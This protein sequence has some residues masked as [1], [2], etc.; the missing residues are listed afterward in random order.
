MNY[1]EWLERTKVFEALTLRKFTGCNVKVG[2][3]VYAASDGNGT[4]ML[5]KHQ[6][7]GRHLDKVF[8]VDAVENVDFIRMK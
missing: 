5:A 2:A 6:V 3:K 7:N 1:N 8:C 4:I